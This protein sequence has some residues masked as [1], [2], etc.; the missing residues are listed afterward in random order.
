MDTP[1]FTHAATLA[2]DTPDGQP[3][4]KQYRWRVEDFDGRPRVV[5]E[6][7]RVGAARWSALRSPD[8]MAELLALTSAPTAEE[9]P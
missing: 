8:R 1:A 7:R 5:G 2:V 4:E 9:S 6:H 3:G